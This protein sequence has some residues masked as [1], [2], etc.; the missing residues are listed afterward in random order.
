MIDPTITYGRTELARELRSAAH[1]GATFIL[2]VTVV[3]MA[4]IL[5]GHR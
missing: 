5:G 3:I 2:A 1:A 4:W